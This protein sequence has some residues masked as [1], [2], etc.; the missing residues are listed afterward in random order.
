M[1]KLLKRMWDCDVAA[2]FVTLWG[3]SALFAFV[4]VLVAR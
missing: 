1:Y 2:I 4:P 3:L